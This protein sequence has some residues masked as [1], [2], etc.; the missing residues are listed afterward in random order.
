VAHDLFVHHVGSRTAAGAG[1]VAEPMA[2]R[3][4]REP[5]SLGT[6]AVALRS[7]PAS[8]PRVSLTMIVRDEEKNLPACLTSIQ[9]LFDE[10]VIVDTGSTDRTRE[11][12]RSFG[13]RVFDFV[14]VRDFAAARNAAL[15]QATGDYAFWLD[16]DDVLDPSQR[17]RL[18]ALLNSLKLAD[19]A[20]YV[21]RCTCESDRDSGGSET[22]V[23]HVRLFPVREDIRWTYRVHEQIL[24]ALRKAGIPVRWTDV[25]VRHTG[26]SDPT[27]RRR[28]LDRDE[29]ILQEEL[30]EHPGDPFVLFNLGS[31]A[32]E[33]QDWRAALGY[34]TRSLEGSA[35]TELL[36]REAVIRRNAGDPSGAES[37]W[38]RV[39]TLKKPERFSSVDMG[40]YGHIT[41]RNLA[42][43]C[44][45]RGALGEAAR[46]WAEVLDDRPNDREAV[47]ACQRLARP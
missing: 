26:Y 18:K 15:A 17:D 41:R 13:A 39:L 25:S 31:I 12:A 3:E 10:M 38:R 44:E 19:K 35:P 24:P 33:R 22:V 43:L 32:V 7:A 45:E 23:D 2:Q 21:V 34:L 27:L 42:A 14:W 36:F 6:D 16:A 20:A 46:L 30:R 11:I 9:G 29:A 8:R 1:T 4:T 5:W 28:K 40:I 37:C 47:A